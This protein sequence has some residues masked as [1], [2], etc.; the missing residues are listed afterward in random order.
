[1]LKETSIAN[2]LA[3]GTVQFGIPYG[4]SNENGQINSREVENIL[5]LARQNG[6]DTVIVRRYF[7]ANL[8][9]GYP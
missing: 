6:V 4:I 2:K 9:M 1:M 3:L 8:L 7:A 5:S